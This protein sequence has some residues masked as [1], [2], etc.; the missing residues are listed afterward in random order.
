MTELTQERKTGFGWCQNDKG[1]HVGEKPWYA[2]GTQLIEKAP[3]IEEGIKLAGLDW[4]VNLKTLQTEDGVKTPFFGVMRSDTNTCLGSVTKSYTPL[5]NTDAF[6]FFEPFL[7]SGQASLDCAGSFRNGRRIWI[8]AKINSEDMIFN[9]NEGDIVQKYIL[10]SNSHD[11]GSAVHIGYIPFR[12]CCL[13]SLTAAEN[14]KK[15]QLIK[16]YHR[17]N[18]ADTVVAVQGMMDLINQQFITTEETY[19]EMMKKPVDKKSFEKYAKVVFSKESLER[20]FREETVIPEYEVE[21]FR[22]Q[23]IEQEKEEIEEKQSKILVR[24]REIYDNEKNHNAWTAYNSVN[25]YLNHERGRDVESG[26]NSLW[27][28]SARNLDRRALAAAQRL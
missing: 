7:E 9:E 25:Y 11:G 15:S 4:D 13:N 8:V 5:Q 14:S 1:F 19:R 28:E 26:F 23:L 24:V 2:V 12:I 27:F 22:K 17:R 16:V 6:K 3:T 20:A 18:V 21:E 10:L